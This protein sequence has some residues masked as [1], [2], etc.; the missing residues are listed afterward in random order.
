MITESEYLK[1]KAI[2]EEY[3]EERVA[4]S[5]KRVKLSSFGIEMQQPK[6]KDKNRQGTVIDRMKAGTYDYTV[7]VKWDGGKSEWMHESQVKYI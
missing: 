5:T 6:P 7:Q 2:V 1:A 3:E 4:I